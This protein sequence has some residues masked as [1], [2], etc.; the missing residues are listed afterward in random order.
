MRIYIYIYK[1]IYTRVGT[2]AQANDTRSAIS[3]SLSHV[4]HL[5]CSYSSPIFLSQ[6]LNA[7]QQKFKKY[8]LSMLQKSIWTVDAPKK[9]FTCLDIHTCH[10]KKV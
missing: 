2:C 8:K 6:G 4:T 10:I 5:S 7:R 1:Y 3:L 9:R